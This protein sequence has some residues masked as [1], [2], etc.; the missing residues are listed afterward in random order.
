MSGLSRRI[1]AHIAEL[2]YENLP[3]AA[4]DAAKRSLLDAIGVSLGAS[5]LCEECRAFVDM[6]IDA[7]GAPTCSLFGRS[8]RAPA[9][10]AAFA[11]GALAHAL[12]FEDAFD[13]AP[14]HPNAAL[15]PA[16]LATAQARGGV[17]GR[18]LITALAAGCDLA[19]RMALCVRTR[20]ETYG[21]YPPPIFGAFAA[22]AGAGKGAGLSAEELLDAFSLV[23][24]Q[25][26]CPGEIKH[27]PGSAV[28]AVREAFPA[29]AAVVSVDLARRGV[30]GFEEPLEGKAGFFRLYVD[31]DYDEAL[32]L[33]RLGDRFL[34]SQ[35]SFKPWPACRGTHA[36][37]EAALALRS[38]WRVEPGRIERIDLWG[39]PLQQMLAQP[40]EAKRAPKTAI[41]AKFS[42][43]F[44]VA[45]ALV[46]GEVELG[47]FS[48][49]ALADARVLALARR[50][51]HHVTEEWG[52]DD[53]AS[54][55]VRLLLG[56]G[57]ELV[58]EIREPCGAASN[59]MSWESLTAKAARCA[60]LAR[61]PI[62][63]A[64]VRRLASVIG[65][66]EA[67]PDAVRAILE[68]IGSPPPA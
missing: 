24:C 53:A 29:M 64:S 21:W 30:R 58:C 62:A 66:V 42:S 9:H 14:I 25:A 10:L 2:R 65:A 31:G 33:D 63:E 5:G 55:R 12:D 59:P 34:G 41:D 57:S 17:D 28:R 20:A 38:A 61:T 39:G 1:A 6:A 54:G 23:L 49:D 15:V 47:S 11:N 4:I 27:S 51:T 37:I 56:N 36:F 32:L 43:P 3:A 22:T 68:A 52:R 16:L 19:C 7:R 44:V 40:H 50:V 67:E 46:H 60:A 18:T 48:T 45:T 13:P 8:E 35:V 26:T